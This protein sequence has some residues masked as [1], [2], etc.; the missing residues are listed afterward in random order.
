MTKTIKIEGMKCSHCSGRVE[1]ALNAIPGVQAT[2]DL[3]KKTAVVTSGSE[4]DDSV[5]E[6]AITEAGYT[7]QA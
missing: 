1:R 2:V 4:I 7:I 6:R 3:A 5:L